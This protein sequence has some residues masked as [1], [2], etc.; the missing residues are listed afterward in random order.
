MVV[1]KIDKWTFEIE[2]DGTKLVVSL[3]DGAMLVI[4]PNIVVNQCPLVLQAVVCNS[5]TFAVMLLNI[6]QGE[7][8]NYFTANDSVHMRNVKHA[9]NNEEILDMYTRYAKSVLERYRKL[10]N[11]DAFANAA[12]MM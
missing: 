10:N 2:K 8:N 11:S 4:N 12:T 1:N 6:L 3:Y 9:D 7:H 5:S